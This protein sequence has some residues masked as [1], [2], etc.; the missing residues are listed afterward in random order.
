MQ[1]SKS[2]IAAPS[3]LSPKIQDKDGNKESIFQGKKISPHFRAQIRAE[4]QR[5]FSRIFDDGVIH[6]IDPAVL[7]HDPA[8]GVA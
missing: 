5:D 6:E 7:E 3:L 4:L 8:V 2:V 1:N